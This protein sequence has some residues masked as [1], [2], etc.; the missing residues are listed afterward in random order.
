MVEQKKK[1]LHG[2][3]I[4]RLEIMKVLVTILFIVVCFDV[5][6]QAPVRVQKNYYNDK[7]I[8]AIDS[9]YHNFFPNSIIVSLD[10]GFDDSLY[11]TVNEEVVLNRYLK[12]DESIGLAGSFVISF[13][14]SSDIKNLRLK[15]VGKKITIEE[16][17]SLKYKSLRI[18]A[19][20]PPLFLYTNQFPMRE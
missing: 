17:V 19:S 11:I 3:C 2:C 20:D 9:F 12:T 10:D 1:F 14:D 13:K 18:F 7:P 4:I 16:R 8:T 5:A 6:G 15:F